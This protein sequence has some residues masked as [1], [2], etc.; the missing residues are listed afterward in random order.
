MAKQPGVS[1][2]IPAHG[3]ADT[4]DRC[5]VALAGQTAPGESYEVIVV[6]DG[7]QDDTGVRVQAHEG[8][9]LLAQNQAARCDQILDLVYDLKVDRDAIIDRNMY[10][11]A[12]T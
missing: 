8:V 6:D 12:P 10:L 7:S 5:L 1:V 4:I 2:V 3:V 9:T 11:H